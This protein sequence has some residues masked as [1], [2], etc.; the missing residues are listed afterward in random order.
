LLESSWPQQFEAICDIPNERLV[1]KAAVHARSRF[2]ELAGRLSDVQ[3][4]EMAL[5]KCKECGKDVS[6]KAAACPNCGAPMPAMSAN[7]AESIRKLGAFAQSRWLGGL[8]FFGGLAWLF[9]A[10]QI[11]GPQAFRQ[12]LGG[13][14]LWLIGGGAAWYIVAE[15]ERNLYERKMKKA[16][17]K[18]YGD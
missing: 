18:R 8:A 9:F 13:G 17:S 4:E 1:A 3:G 16:G 14:A 15:I 12:A 2:G 7:Q 5:S 11:G 10:A 6:D